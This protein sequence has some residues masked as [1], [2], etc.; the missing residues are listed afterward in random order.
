MAGFIN[1]GGRPQ[2]ADLDKDFPNRLQKPVDT[3]YGPYADDFSPEQR[4]L[5]PFGPIRAQIR[6]LAAKQAAQKSPFIASFRIDSRSLDD[7]PPFL[8]LGLLQGAERL[9]ALLLARR[10]VEAEIGHPAAHAL[11]GHRGGGTV[12]VQAAE[13]RSGW[14]DA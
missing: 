10:N 1:S 3:A 7:G 9:R 8:D 11:A 14:I 13:I 5:G 4:K 12:R 6:E 2:K